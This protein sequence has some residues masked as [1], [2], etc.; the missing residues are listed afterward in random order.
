MKSKNFKYVYCCSYLAT[1][2][3]RKRSTKNPHNSKQAAIPLPIKKKNPIKHSLTFA[4]MWDAKQP[5]CTTHVYTPCARVLCLTPP[6]GPTY[7]E[8][9]ECTNFGCCCFYDTSNE[10]MLNTI[11]C[12][13]TTSDKQQ[14]KQEGATRRE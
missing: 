1:Y 12:T 7:V 8:G 11:K 14:A 2:D 6:V 4:R 13:I 5:V 10:S 3:M 9:G